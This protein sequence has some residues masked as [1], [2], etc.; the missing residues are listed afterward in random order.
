V[1]SKHFDY[2]VI[3]KLK[4]IQFIYENKI[5]C[6]KIIINSQIKIIQNLKIKLDISKNCL[7]VNIRIKLN[8]YI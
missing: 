8:W 7:T 4:Y 6:D 5:N 2:I 1:A 3:I